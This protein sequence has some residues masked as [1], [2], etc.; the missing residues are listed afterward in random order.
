MVGKIRWARI[1]RRAEDE[2]WTDG[3]ASAGIG[4]ERPLEELVSAFQ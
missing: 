3:G 2:A 1:W 4:V